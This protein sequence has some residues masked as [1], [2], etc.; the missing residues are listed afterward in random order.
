MFGMPEITIPKI[1]RYVNDGDI[2]MLGNLEI[3][4]LHTPGHTQGGVCY[5]IENNIFTGDTIFKGSV[6]RCDLEGGDFSQLVDSI[7]SKIYTLP[8]N[9]TIYPGHG[10][11][12]NIGWEKLNNRFL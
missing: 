2:L 8:D 12:S 3:K 1:D 4:V 5:L 7:Q 11:A 10:K 9:I 6:G